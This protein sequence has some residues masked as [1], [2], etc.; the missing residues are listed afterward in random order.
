MRYKVTLFSNMDQVLSTN[1]A[2]TTDSFATVCKLASSK[3]GIQRRGGSALVGGI[4]VVNDKDTRRAVNRVIVE[5]RELLLTHNIPSVSEN[6]GSCYPHPERYLVELYGVSRTRLYVTEDCLSTYM[7]GDFP[8]ALGKLKSRE[9][10]HNS[11][12][13]IQKET[14]VHAVLRDTALN[15]AW[16]F[17]NVPQGP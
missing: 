12:G 9:G 7:Y 1:L 5:D 3:T 10:F 16:T 6:V 15:A 13:S 4:E 14:V 2:M 8:T 17:H 11:T